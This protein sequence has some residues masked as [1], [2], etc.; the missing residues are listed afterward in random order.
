VAEPAQVVGFAGLGV[1]GSAMSSHLLAA[2]WTVVGYDIDPARLAAHSAL[3]GTCAASPVALAALAPVIVTSLPS[4]QALLDVTLGPDGLAA[5][6][7][8]GLVVIETSTLPLDAKEQARLA[9]AQRDAQLL[10]CTVSGTGA[11]ARSRDLVAYL[12]GEAAA[13]ER[14][15]QVL[16]VMTR[17][18]Y[19][20]GAFGNGSK[21]KMIA[22]MLV[23]VHN[24]AAAEAL[25]LAEGAGLDL[26]AVLAAVADGA[27]SSR[28]F[29]VRGPAM[30]AGSY[31][32][33][34]IRT[35]L[36][37]K[38]ID[39]ITGLARDC[40]VPVPLFALATV[41]Y[42]AALAQGR[43]DD[44]TACVHAILRQLAGLAH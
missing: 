16:R 12:S 29:E 41:Y 31:T 43:G 24:V 40:R 7:A 19:D 4:G 11:Q 13:K 38:D 20:V 15:A 33:P 6:A 21:I 10:D 34:G 35:S 9:L 14:A 37:A 36:F 39:L 30:A 17:R 22:N 2:G 27:G 18:H 1:M 26:D 28:M 23:T 3:G 44:D 32:G 5:G 25:V 8:P 42:Q